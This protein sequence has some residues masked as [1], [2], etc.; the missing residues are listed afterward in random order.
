MKHNLLYTPGWKRFNWYSNNQKKL[1]RM[2]NQAMMKSYRKEPFWKIGVLV[3]RTHAKDVEKK[4]NTAWQDSEATEMKQVLEYHTFI[5]KGKGG[6]AP[7]GNKR[8]QYH[9]TYD[10]KHD[11]QHKAR[12]VAGRNLT[13]PNTESELFC[14]AAFDW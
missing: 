6:T 13:D 1:Q 11:G 14:F 10:V 5:R 3:P 8:I 12:L 9:N 7:T 4:N 2:I